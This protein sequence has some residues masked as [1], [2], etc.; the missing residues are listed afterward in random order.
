MIL[1]ELYDLWKRW[2]D[3]VCEHRINNE[4]NG[5]E[6][7]AKTMEY[8]EELDRAGY[9]TFFDR[10][11]LNQKHKERFL[12]QD[13]KSKKPYAFLQTEIDFIYSFHKCFAMRHQTRLQYY[14]HDLAQKKK[15][16]RYAMNIAVGDFKFKTDKAD[17]KA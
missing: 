5:Y 4:T 15:R 9:A 6:W 12:Q 10:D 2:T 1:E 3:Q 13:V 7:C 11:E 16:T 17:Q 14:R 8:S